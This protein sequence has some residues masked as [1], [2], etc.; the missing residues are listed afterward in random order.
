M[1]LTRGLWAALLAVGA[2]LHFAAAQTALDNVTAAT[3]GQTVGNYSNVNGSS[4]SEVAASDLTNT[5]NYRCARGALVCVLGCVSRVAPCRSILSSCSAWQVANANYTLSSG[6][7]SLEDDVGLDGY[8]AAYNAAGGDA[9]L[10]TSRVNATF[11]AA[12]L[13][14]G[15]AVPRLALLGVQ[16]RTARCNGGGGG[17]FGGGQN[18]T[19]IQANSTSSVSSTLSGTASS[20]SFIEPFLVDYDR[21][22]SIVLTEGVATAGYAPNSPG[23]TIACC[24]LVPNLPDLPCVVDGCGVPSDGI[25]RYNQPHQIAGP[26][27]TPRSRPTSG[28]PAGR[29]ACGC[30]A[31]GVV[32][33]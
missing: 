28:A 6:S 5:G 15:A 16:L 25:S 18:S 32:V 12:L 31:C 9:S 29:C 17:A 27:S 21:A 8:A 20:V 10:G 7:A 33:V 14:Q 23:S 1:R 3:D 19:Y 30:D 26:R 11:A 24:N 2:S 13:F 4:S 22:L